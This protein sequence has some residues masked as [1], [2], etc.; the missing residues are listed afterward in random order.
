MRLHPL[1][2]SVI[3]SLIAVMLSGCGQSGKETQPVAAAP[4]PAPAPAE[5]LASASE[6]SQP[7]TAK[8]EPSPT[9]E[10][11]AATPASAEEWADIQKF[12][13]TMWD[14]S[15]KQELAHKKREV[16]SASSVKKMNLVGMAQAQVTYIGQIDKARAALKRT[17]L[18]KVADKDAETFI[19]DAYDSLNKKLVLEREQTGAV[20]AIMAEQME[21]PTEDEIATMR[22]DI[23][24]QTMRIVM[25]LNRIYWTY[26]YKSE[27]IDDNYGLMKGAKPASTVSF[28]RG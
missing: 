3:A 24:F 19:A 14:I 15:A 28:S 11:P 4:S 22:R 1:R 23:D 16:D 21:K 12:I 5:A 8:S 25:S 26:G 6:K 9:G 2:L 27:D 7:P 20:L 17:K 13:Q 10:R 18:P